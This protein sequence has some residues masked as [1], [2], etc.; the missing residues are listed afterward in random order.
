MVTTLHEWIDK[1]L[2][3]FYAQKDFYEFASIY[4][5]CALWSIWKERNS[6]VFE[7]KRPCPMS[8]VTRATIL[9]NDYY[10]FWK[11]KSREDMP[12]VTNVSTSKNWRPP[13]VGMLKLNT[14][15]SFNRNKCLAHAGVIIRNEYGDVLT[16]LSKV[17]HT[18]SPLLAEALSLREGLVFAVSLG[19]QCLV[20]EN[21]SLDLIRACR[22]E[23][24]NGEILSLI[25]DIQCL[26]TRF[27]KIG[28]T[29]VPREGNKVAHQIAALASHHN[30]P[31]CWTWRPP[32]SL[33]SLIQKD[34][35]LLLRHSNREDRPLFSL[36]QN[37]SNI[38]RL[39]SGHQVAVCSRSGFPFDPG[40]EHGES[41][42][43]RT[44][45]DGFN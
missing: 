18:S 17:F 21:D 14:D 24:Q 20:A 3:E 1:K 4:L 27:Q 30:L 42:Y 19:I 13:P 40:W 10:S 33:S 6:A 26:K 31:A 41:S 25:G 35:Q 29:W 9:Q 28:F 38:Q 5:C 11:N 44:R 12:P 15:S 16:G 43:S 34:K 7:R 45:D 37:G 32:P 22:G 8:T 39:T 2:T 23:L 36:Q